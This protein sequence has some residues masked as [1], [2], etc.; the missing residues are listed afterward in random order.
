MASGAKKFKFI[1]PGIFMNEIDRSQ[2][3]LQPEAIGPVIIGRTEKGPGMR[4]VTVSSYQEYVNT[5]GAPVPGAD[6]GDNWRE[7]DF[8]GPTYASYAAQAWL[9]SGEAPVTMVRLLGTQHQDVEAG[10]K[11]GWT[12]TNTPNP[13]P[14]SNGGAYGLFLINS[15]NVS[16]SAFRAGNGPDSFLTGGLA[17][18]WYLP[19]GSA[20]ALSGTWR[21]PGVSD[22]VEGSGLTPYRTASSGML[23]QS[24]GDDKQFKAIV[25][26]GVDGGIPLTSSVV[27]FDFN[28]DSDIYIRKVFNT[29]PPQSNTTITKPTSPSYFRYWLGET[30]DQFIERR[31]TNT[32]AGSVYGFIAALTSGSTE[33]AYEQ[34]QGNFQDA[35]SGWFFAQDT[36][37]PS[38]FEPRNTPKLFR[39][40]SRKQGEWIQRNVKISIEQIRA[41]DY[42][43]FDAYGTFSLV[44]RHVRDNDLA[45][46]IIERYDNLNLNPNS[47]D[48]IAR[49]IGD[50]YLEWSDDDRRMRAYGDYDNQSP[51]IRIEVDPAVRRGAIDATLLPFG[52]F[53]PPRFLKFTIFSGSAATLK[54]PG[55][56]AA[57]PTPYFK[58]NELEIQNTPVKALNDISL[59]PFEM[60]E[61]QKSLISTG[62]RKADHGAGIEGYTGSFDWPRLRLRLSAS[63]GGLTNPTDAYWGVQTTRTP[64]SKR[65]DPSY[66][67]LV[68]PL[69]LNV[70]SFAETAGLTEYSFAFTMDN[71]VSA[72]RGYYY[73]SGSRRGQ[74]TSHWLTYGGNY[75]GSTVT[76]V[77]ATSGSTY[78]TLLDAGYDKFTAPMFGAFD[79]L[80]VQERAPFR[81][82]RIDDNS[83]SFPREYYN[84]TYNTIRRAIDTVADPEFVE[85]NLMT[86]PGITDEDL[87]G[88]LVDVCEE[89]GDALGIIDLKGDY[90]P[91][92]EELPDS[93]AT[94]RQPNVT[95]TISNMRSRGIN[96]SYGCAFF[97][98]VQIKDTQTGRLVDVPSS[99]VAL[100]TFG[101][102]QARSEL[103]FAP[104]GFT[105]G[106]LSNGAAGIPVT[107]VKM[108]LTSKDRD[109]LY[110][111]N[112]N[113]IATFPSEGIVVFGQKTLQVTQS[114]LDRINVRRLLIYVKKEISRIAAGVLFDPNVQATWDRFTG[115]VNPFLASVKARFGL[116]DFKVV[117]D[118]T[119]TTDDLID[120]NILYAKIYLKPARAIEF[121]ALDF[122]ITRTGAS[123]DD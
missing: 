89:R 35:K 91:M 60:S 120:R 98:F 68:R 67:D 29:S 37:L 31:V 110:A 51:Y 85:A 99:V 103:W 58:R 88:H 8:D 96:S 9:A 71:V 119:T 70:D 115:A 104:A 1:S 69:P 2:I 97:P 75:T 61:E 27:C 106:G 7:G 111:A 100:G 10:G 87:T 44:L 65:F 38:S 52:F 108:R 12:T 20:I 6:G 18:V 21:Q 13:L 77:T 55:P 59:M 114:A 41:S 101:T 76:S 90:V 26:D 112:I 14:Q 4:P 19:S 17:A 72:S 79:G 102:S 45:P 36:G 109:N 46:R 56:D 64:S 118:N 107:G 80:D 84:Y 39:V 105:R 122:I 117:L 48:Y 40:I 62:L 47:T 54:P 82:T 95:T 66:I 78:K 5:F 92:A 83:T 30:Y 53:G 25:V 116:T 113:P 57:H 86:V 23:I 34:M 33:T 22:G 15:G 11:A 73:L 49:R 74:G 24:S 81:N 94:N 121:I 3:P 16:G 123:F 42:A 63:D 43:E 50:K 32:G 28:Q 93:T